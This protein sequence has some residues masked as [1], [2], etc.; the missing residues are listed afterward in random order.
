MTPTAGSNFQGV[1]PTRSASRTSTA[2]YLRV[3]RDGYRFNKSFIERHELRGLTTRGAVFR[4]GAVV[5]L[6]PRL[7]L[8]ELVAC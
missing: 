5:L 1:T 2:H 8:G 3:R 6:A 7:T 4:I